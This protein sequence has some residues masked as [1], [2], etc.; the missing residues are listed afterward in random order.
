MNAAE[1]YQHFDQRF[2][3]AAGNGCKRLSGKTS[4]WKLPIPG[5]A[6]QFN[7]ATN[8]KV[9][10]L[11]GELLWPGEFRLLL[12]WITGKGADRNQTEVSF[13]QYTTAPEVDAFCRIERLALQKFLSRKPDMT[14]HLGDRLGPDYAPRANWDRWNYY[15]DA[16]D[17]SSWGDWYGGTLNGWVE[18]FVSAPE[19]RDDWCRRV[20]GSN[21]P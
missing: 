20:L 21:I 8:A 4:K 16:Q 5:G 14:V 10:G 15:Y 2:S 11:L 18:R 12:Y 1:F 9:S 3:L 6:L 19:S 17:A 7:F 13:F